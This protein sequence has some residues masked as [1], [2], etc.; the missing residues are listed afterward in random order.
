MRLKLFIVSIGSVIIY[1][2]ISIL[3]IFFTSVLIIF[4]HF[5]LSASV[6]D[7]QHL[8][9]FNKN[10]NLLRILLNFLSINFLGVYPNC[11]QNTTEQIVE[12]YPST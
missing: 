1:L 11:S 8:Y 6:N 4:E 7:S 10:R 3:G 12:T 5:S 9:D 2:S